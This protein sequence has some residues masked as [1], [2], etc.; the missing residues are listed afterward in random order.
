MTI[1]SKIIISPFGFKISSEKKKIS[2]DGSFKVEFKNMFPGVLVV[3]QWVMNP[4][5]IY[6]DAS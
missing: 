4:A 2:S 1:G 5:N 6:K 3:A